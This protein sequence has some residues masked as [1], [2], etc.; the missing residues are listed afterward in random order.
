MLAIALAAA[1]LATA[2]ATANVTEF[3]PPEQ[4]DVGVNLSPL[5]TDGLGVDEW[6]RT[7]T[8]AI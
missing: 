1:T 3:T 7:S 2:A 5:T 6:K 4:L 8:R